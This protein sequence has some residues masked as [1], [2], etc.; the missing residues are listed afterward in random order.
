M[1]LP[2][3]IMHT[4]TT[5]DSPFAGRIRKTM[6]PPAFLGHER[7]L[8]PSHSALWRGLTSIHTAP[9][10]VSAV[11]ALIQNAHGTVLKAMGWLQHKERETLL[12]S[13]AVT[14]TMAHDRRR[15]RA[16]ARLL[17]RAKHLGAEVHT[18]METLLRMTHNITAA[19]TRPNADGVTVNVWNG[20]PDL[21]CTCT[22]QVHHGPERCTFCGTCDVCAPYRKCPN[23][24]AERAHELACR[25]STGQPEEL[26]FRPQGPVAW[27]AAPTYER[28]QQLLRGHDPA[29]AFR[30][31]EA[32]RRQRPPGQA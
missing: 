3:S 29:R 15:R 9:C 30:R 10:L 27:P 20:T 1:F 2:A 16:W 12:K 11:S 19:T 14:M 6:Y 4:L 24:P 25:G 22:R 13:L 7:G 5:Y 28:R 8:V 32:R 26:H 17:D 31:E 18:P 23:M 21:S